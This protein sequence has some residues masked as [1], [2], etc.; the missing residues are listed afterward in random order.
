MVSAVCAAPELARRGLSPSLLIR[1]GARQL[2]CG[3][4]FLR[5]PLER[6]GLAEDGAVRRF[7]PAFF[8]A[9]D[10]DLAARVRE[11]FFSVY[12]NSIEQL[13][14]YATVLATLFLGHKFYQSYRVRALR[15]KFPL[16]I[17]GWGTRGNPAQSG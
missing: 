10:T 4:A 12:E 7:F 1:R 14:L 16:V 15:K 5:S 8:P 13:A 3:G 2:R 6:R 11:Y 9:W 17:G